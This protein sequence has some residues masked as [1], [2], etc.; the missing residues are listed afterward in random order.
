MDS[1]TKE[2]RQDLKMWVLPMLY[3]LGLV[4]FLA[5]IVTLPIIII[6]M[7]IKVIFL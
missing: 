4:L 6:M 3:L 5:S 1:T 2:V 7:A